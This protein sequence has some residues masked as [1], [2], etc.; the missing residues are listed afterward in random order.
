MEE[1]RGTW[2][3]NNWLQNFGWT[4]SKKTTALDTKE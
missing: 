4:T 2:E 1:I 3:N